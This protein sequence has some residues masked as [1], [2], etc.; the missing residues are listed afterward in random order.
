MH[1]HSIVAF[2]IRSPFPPKKKGE[3]HDSWFTI[4]HDDPEIN[5]Y[6]DSCGWSTPQMSDADKKIVEYMIEWD[7]AFPYYTS[8][9]LDS[10]SVIVNHQYK[11]RSLPA[12]E[13]LA[14]VSAVWSEI[15]WQR[16]HR[17]ILTNR[18]ISTIFSISSSPIDNLRSSLVQGQSREERMRNF[19][20]CIFRAYLRTNRK[21]YQHPK[22]HIHHWRIQWHWLQKLDRFLFQRCAVCGKRFTKWGTGNV[23]G[24][25]DGKEI[26]HP[27]CQAQREIDNAK[28]I[29]SY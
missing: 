22:W 13:C 18:E 24:S 12:G 2:E 27:E 23:Y 10:I 4:W 29:D 28:R 1:D 15:V 3:Y 20:V 16:E 9:Y 25:W 11:F 26:W 7:K 14:L 5:N 19:I 21:W 17:S 8:P 6:E